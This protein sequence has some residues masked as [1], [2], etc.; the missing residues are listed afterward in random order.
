MTK[1]KEGYVRA[2]RA[3]R[4]ALCGR[5]AMKVLEATVFERLCFRVQLRMSLWKL[6]RTSQAASLGANA[7]GVGPVEHD[8]M[9]AA[10]A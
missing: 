4:I 9:L 2:L 7:Y 5:Y 10:K 1:D 6:H 8:E 3:T